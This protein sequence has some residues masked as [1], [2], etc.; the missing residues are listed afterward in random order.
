MSCSAAFALRLSQHFEKH[1]N[2]VRNILL[3]AVRST[4]ARCRKGV[5][6][7]PD[8]EKA[9]IAVI[10]GDARSAYLCDLFLKDGFAVR[11]FALEKA[12]LAVGA[13]HAPSAENAVHGAVAA[14]LPIPLTRGA[15]IL[16]AP[17]SDGV[18]TITEIFSAMRPEIL[19]LAGG[20]ADAACACAKEY[21]LTLTDYLKREELA[22]KNA[23][24]TAEGAIAAAMQALPITLHGAK[25]LVTG[26]GRVARPLAAKLHALGAHVTVAVRREAD[27]ALCYAAGLENIHIDD[28]R[29]NAG[30]FDVIF[31]TVPAV[32]FTETVLAHV[33]KDTP[34][35]DLASRPGGVERAAAARLGVQLIEALS[36]PG[37]VAP[38][39]AARAIRDT[40]YTILR[41]EAVLT[42]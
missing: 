42:C 3:I 1:L 22:V 34:V 12:A 24:P 31:N 11:A 26:Y 6:D 15:Q 40:I 27:F 25:C 8:C 18:F 41:E 10:G 36:L 32:L 7:L 20:A 30:A 14:V 17:L 37:K 16:N 2:G 21:G 19:L 33:R 9:T 5:I 38:L 39:S 13:A 35:I 4:S 23:V 28:I 29:G